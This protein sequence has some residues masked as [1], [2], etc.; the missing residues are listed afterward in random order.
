MRTDAVHR[1]Q[2]FGMHQKAGKFVLVSFQPEQNAQSH[3]VD[4]AFHC[5]IHRFRMPGVIVLRSGRMQLLVAFLMISFLKQDISADPG[6]VQFAVIFHRGGGN[7]DIDPA[8]GAILVLNAVNRFDAFQNIF[9][10]IV[11][12][13]FS[14]FDRQ[15]LM[16]HVLQG[17]HF[18]AHFL[19]RHFFAGNMFV[20]GMIRTIDAAVDA[21]V[22]KIQRR[23]QNNPVAV[24]VFFYLFGQRTDFRV[25]VRRFTGQQNRSFAMGKTLAQ[26]CLVENFINQRYVVFVGFGIFQSRQYFFM[27]D[28]FLSLQ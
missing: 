12:R 13:I 22:G 15:P 18:A 9:D 2:M 16:P 4:A 24:K 26:F 3:V 5:P 19:L 14:G 27:A 8:D 7:I 17:D 10:R 25:F 23:K 28:K 20:F 11:D 21:I 1:F 6:L